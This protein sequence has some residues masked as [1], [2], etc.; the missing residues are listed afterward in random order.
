M[1]S[2]S[3]SGIIRK[4]I[5]ALFSRDGHFLTMLLSVIWGLKGGHTTRC[6]QLVYQ[7]AAS[8]SDGFLIL[9]C[10]DDRACTQQISLHTPSHHRGGKRPLRRVPPLALFH[11]S[12]LVLERESVHGGAPPSRTKST[13]FHHLAHLLSSLPGSALRDEST[14]DSDP[15]WSPYLLVLR[16]LLPWIDP[17]W[18]PYLSCSAPGCNG[19]IQVIYFIQGCWREL[20]PLQEGHL[21]PSNKVH[22]NPCWLRPYFSSSSIL[23]SPRLVGSLAVILLRHFLVLLHL[24]SGWDVSPSPGLVNLIALSN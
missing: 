9:S 1:R 24:L 11:Q 20:G 6:V 23:G 18:S 22:S 7:H 12:S 17:K 5:F 2:F 13:I 14:S 10:P 8:L 4:F 16:R 21:W 19:K 3:L 15:K